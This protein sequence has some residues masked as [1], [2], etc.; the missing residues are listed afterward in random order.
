MGTTR[1]TRPGTRLGG[2]GVGVGAMG[3]LVALVA[4]AIATVQSWRAWEHCAHTP[5]PAGVRLGA[6]VDSHPS[7]LPLGYSCVWPDGAASI[8]VT[9]ANWPL[10]IAATVGVV[11]IVSAGW[12]VARSSRRP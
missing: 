6:P 12:M 11:A 9:F 5:V 1:R 7:L 10:T 4:V 8:S 2:V 3:A